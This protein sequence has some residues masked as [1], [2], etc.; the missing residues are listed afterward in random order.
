MDAAVGRPIDGVVL[1]VLLCLGAEMGAA[2]AELTVSQVHLIFTP[3]PT[4]LLKINVHHKH[5]VVFVS[6]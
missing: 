5:V 3:F 6:V 2:V 4:A 1:A